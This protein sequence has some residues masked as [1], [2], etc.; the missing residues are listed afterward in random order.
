MPENITTN[1]GGKCIAVNATFVR[2]SNATPYTAGDIV[3]NNATTSVL[4]KFAGLARLE[5]GSGAIVKARLLTDLKTSTAVYRLKLF[6]KSEVTVGVAGD[7][8]P[9]KTLYANKA[10][11]VGFIDFP[12]CSAGADGTNNTAAFALWTGGN[13]SATEPAGPLPYVCDP[14][15]PTGGGAAETSLY[16]VLIDTAGSTPASAQNF[17][18]ELTVLQN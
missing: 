1:V 9:D 12:A 11:E 17:W 8:L 15:K 7:N 2:P 10:Y 16:G 4:M 3:S 14:T 6:T 5:G 13:G 18:V